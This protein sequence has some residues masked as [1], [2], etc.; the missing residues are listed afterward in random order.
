VA[1]FQMCCNP[2]EP[3]G[4]EGNERPDKELDDAEVRVERRYCGMG[5]KAMLGF[6]CS[7]S[8]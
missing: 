2:F 5:E 1:E 7:C 4:A 6:Q 8:S 3:W